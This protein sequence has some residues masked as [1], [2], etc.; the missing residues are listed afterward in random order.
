MSTPPWAR[1][2]LEADGRR[3]HTRLEDFDR[4]RQRDIEASLLGWTVLR[5]VWADLI[6]RPAWVCDVVRQHLLRAAA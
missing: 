6:E 2:I 1:L 3:W 4:D 5:F